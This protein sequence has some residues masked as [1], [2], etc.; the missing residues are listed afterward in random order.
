MLE[1]KNLTKRI[2]V[3]DHVKNGASR[4]HSLNGEKPESHT[5][6]NQL[7]FNII[8]QSIYVILCICLLSNCTHFTNNTDL[9]KNSFL[10]F[11][12]SATIG[13]VLDNY[14]Y[15]T[16]TEW[17]EFTTEQG[18]EVVE[19]VGHYEYIDKAIWWDGPKDDPKSYRY[20]E[21]IF[22]F[23][24]GDNKMATVS[25]IVTIQFLI[26]KDRREDSDGHIFKVAYV[27]KKGYSG[28][29]FISCDECISKIY[30]NKGNL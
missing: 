15:F 12:Q 19:F 21:F 18:K 8:K 6:G 7:R 28:E 11:D 27:G 26:N 20:V 25:G 4:Y 3:K 17:N 29:N 14:Q 23:E 16:E 30:M 13:E 9:V 1:L 24:I 2:G 22:D 10:D 5:R